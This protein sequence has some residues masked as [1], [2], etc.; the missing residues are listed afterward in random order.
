MG[1]SFGNMTGKGCFFGTCPI[2]TMWFGN[3]QYYPASG[4]TNFIT[5]DRNS[6]S[7]SSAATSA[8][9]TVSASTSAWTVTSSASWLTVSKQSSTRARYSVTTPY[10]T[11]SRDATLSFQIS[12]T[13]YAT[14][15]VHQAGQAPYIVLIYS[16]EPHDSDSCYGI[17]TVSSNTPYWST[18]VS[19]SPSS[20]LSDFY[21]RK[22]NNTEIYWSWT[23]N[24]GSTYRTGYIEV[25]YGSTSRT[26]EISQNVACSIEVLGGTAKTI[27]AP[28]VQFAISVQ[29]LAGGSAAGASCSIG[30]NSMGVALSE[31]EPVGDTG[32]INFTFT[33]SAN[34]TEND[35]SV[36]ISFTQTGS[37][38]QN[39][40]YA[41]VLQQGVPPGP[42]VEGVTTWAVYDNFI[43]GTA[44]AGQQYLPVGTR[45]VTGIVVVC[46]NAITGD[47]T[48]RITLE[49]QVGPLVPGGSVTSHTITS[50]LCEIVAE[51]TVEVGEN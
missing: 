3:K 15:S 21:V 50:E 5:L 48:A 20:E 35:R 14:F 16:T 34:T 18:R 17:V 38:C 41:Y 31:V 10:D 40:T 12:G 51:S 1:F 43:L 24:T 32:Q 13:T 22:E 44:V 42:H 6:D 28:A 26:A 11:D 4:S 25:Y 46:P 45:D 37:T 7:L 23:E 47:K 30:P 19:T 2:Q 9:I 36:T 8:Y 49:Y 33:C 39:T 27:S 29:S